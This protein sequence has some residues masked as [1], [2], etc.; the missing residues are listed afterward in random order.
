MTPTQTPVAHDN[1]YFGQT[2]YR[3]D[4]DVIWDYFNRRGGVATFGYPVSRTFKLQGFTVQFF[5]RRIVQLDSAGHARL[6][7]VLDPGLMPYSSFN[8]A[9]LPSIDS[10]LVASAPPPSDAMA[11]LNFVTAHAPDSFQGMAVNYH[12]TFLNTVQASIRRMTSPMP[13]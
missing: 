6:L 5:Q 8:G 2:S 7:N 1:R 10:G 12:Q 3:I 4:N 9:T 11:T 13:T